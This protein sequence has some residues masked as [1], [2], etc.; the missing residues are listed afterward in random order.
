MTQRRL[1][2][3]AEN[4]LLTVASK[5]LD[6]G[7]GP[8]PKEG[9]IGLD[10]KVSDPPRVFRCDL[11]SGYEW[12]VA[13]GSIEALYSSHTIEHLPADDVLTQRRLPSGFW[14]HEPMDCLF[15][16]MEEAWRV[17]APGCRF[18]LKWP[19]AIDVRDGK[20][21][22]FTWVDPTHRRAIPIEQMNYF[23]LAGRKEMGVEFYA[24][25]CDWRIEGR[26]QQNEIGGLAFEYQV[27]LFKPT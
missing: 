20:P 16:F 3:Y 15:W 4:E 25:D 12:P 8:R 22:R 13:T 11:A 23:S 10:K 27:T 5:R 2:D 14:R 24:V 19:A 1:A 6:L 21:G 18:E 26:P 17:A 9:F 7:S